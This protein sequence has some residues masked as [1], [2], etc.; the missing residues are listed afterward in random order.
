MK[1]IPCA[2]FAQTPY[3]MTTSIAIH[4]MVGGEADL[5][6]LPAFKNADYYAENLRSLGLFR[7]V[8]VLNK[9]KILRNHKGKSK[10]LIHLTVAQQYLQVDELAREILIPDTRYERIY[11][12]SKAFTSRI[13]SFYYIKHNIRFEL[14]YYDDGEGSYDFRFRIEPTLSDSIARRVLIGKKSLL[15]DGKLYLYDPELYFQINGDDQRNTIRPIS[16]GFA[17]EDFRRNISYVFGVKNSDLISEKVIIIDMI[18][19][20]KYSQTEV[21]RIN[22]VYKSIEERFG[23]DNTIVKRHPRDKSDYTLDCN[24]YENDGMPFECLCTQMDMNTKVLVGL[25]STALVLPKIL[26]DQEP[27]VLLLYRLF[28]RLE[29]SDE[30]RRKQDLFYKSC[31]DR[32]SSK[33]RFFIP[34]SFE[35][36][37]E[38]LKAIVQMMFSDNVSD[39][40]KSGENQ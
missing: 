6:I 39:L 14:V 7:N 33:D 32:Y 5:Y 28:K 40:E 16:H 1:T 11:V 8:R 23:A 31:R 37:D 29:Q 12:S 10:L 38:A 19:E 34:E 17:D 30:A 22:E 9:D 21:E 35:E 25:Y 27:V 13:V 4:K 3:Q 36:L 26:L 24:C 15:T 2:F 20:L 18:K